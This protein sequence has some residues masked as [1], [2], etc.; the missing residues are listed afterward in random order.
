MNLVVQICSRGT[1]YNKINNCFYIIPRVGVYF[2]QNKIG[3][4]GCQTTMGFLNFALKL[5]MCFTRT[6]FENKKNLK[7]TLLYSWGDGMNMYVYC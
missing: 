1:K 2:S 3:I 4:D 7:K 6:L 5:C